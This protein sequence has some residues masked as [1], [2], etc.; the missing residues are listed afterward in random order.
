MKKLLAAAAS[1][2]L[3]ALSGVIPVS[4]DE[5]LGVN[6]AECDRCEQAVQRAAVSQ[7][8]AMRSVQPGPMEMPL[9]FRDDDDDTSAPYI[10]SSAELAGIGLKPQPGVKFERVTTPLPTGLRRVPVLRVRI[11][12]IRTA[13]SDGSEAATITP[14]QVGRLVEQAN[15]VWWSSGIEFQF[16]PAKDFEHRNDTTLNQ[17]SSHAGFEA[18]INNASWDPGTSETSA[19]K[20]ARTAVGNQFPKKVVCFF[21]YGTRFT[22]DDAA[23]RWTRGPG[24]GGF[25]SS[26][27]MYVAMPKGMPEKN[28]LAHEVGHYM[29]VPHTH[30][31]KID[32]VEKARKAIKD[33]VDVRGKTTQTALEALNGD[34]GTITD[35]PSDTGGRIFINKYG[36]NANCA[37][38]HP[39]IMIDVTFNSGY[40]A[41]YKLQP[42]KLN[43]MSYFKHCHAL[44]THHL[45]RR[46]VDRARA[47]LLTGTRNVLIN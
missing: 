24:T 32:T 9:E 34:R 13:N 12:A 8:A 33:W 37:A 14:E 7:R 39:V 40:A 20:S 23:G 15:L 35:T 21:R 6:A 47:A 31:G 44:G 29:Q 27:A 25:S 22:W 10:L 46:Q 18:N 38:N 11:H 45:S 43:V 17:D 28:L 2:V 16:D 30:A 5:L 1:A 42:D 19:N 41:Y 36:E 26:I 4:I 3:I